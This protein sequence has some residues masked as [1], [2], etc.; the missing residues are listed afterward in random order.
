MLET[1]LDKLLNAKLEQPTD[2]TAYDS[3]KLV[4][5]L[6]SAW[7]LVFDNSGYGIRLLRFTKGGTRTHDL[8]IDIDKNSICLVDTNHRSTMSMRYCFNDR[9]SLAD[10]IEDFRIYASI[11]SDY[12]SSPSLHQM[13]LTTVVQK[14]K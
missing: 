11:D 5:I 14:P 7:K 9:S 1:S 12:M 6:Q 3:R 8:E 4:S 2:L 10:F 13:L